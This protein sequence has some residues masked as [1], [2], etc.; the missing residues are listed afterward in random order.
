[1]AD[2]KPRDKSS[3]FKKLGYVRLWRGFRDD[4]LWKKKRK[5][6][7]F[8]AWLDL[9]MEAR[10]VSG[11]IIFKRARFNLK[12]GQLVTSQWM[13]ARRWDWPRG[14]VRN[15]LRKL[16]R[17]NSIAVCGIPKG[18]GHSIITLLNYEEL[19]PIERDDL[20]KAQQGAIL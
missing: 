8:E 9:Y 4:P 2:E 6:S 3:D 5:F 10:G 18:A 13:L 19:N 17:R 11:E 12:R 20:A 14:S 7:Q 16:T 1:M 15:F